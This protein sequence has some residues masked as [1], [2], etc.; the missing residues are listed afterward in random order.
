MNS[1]LHQVRTATLAYLY[2][3]IKEFPEWFRTLT[4]GQMED[5]ADI[6]VSWE[7]DGHGACIK[8]MEEIEQCEVLRA[9][10]FCNGG[11]TEAA[12][13]LSSVR[14]RVLL[15]QAAVLAKVQPKSEISQSRS[16]NGADC[17]A[18]S[19]ESQNVSL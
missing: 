6:L 7:V 8:P 2:D 1:T 10:S 13:L 12:R 4:R 17:G 18:S 5:M 14:D 3:H 19:Q 15:D 16:P 11:M 9:L